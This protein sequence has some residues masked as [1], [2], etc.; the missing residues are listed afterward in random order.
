MNLIPFSTTT[1]SGHLEASLRFGPPGTLVLEFRWDEQWKLVGQG[2]AT[3]AI[4]VRAHELWRST[5]FEA[6]I[7]STNPNT[8]SYLEINVSPRGDWNVY[9]FDGYRN[10]HPPRESTD[11]QLSQFSCGSGRLR[12]VL[13]GPS[14]AFTATRVGLTAVIET[15]DRNIS[16]WALKHPGTQADFHDPR[17]FVAQL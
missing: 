15:T 2:P 3:E 11:W 16:Y 4:G 12:A 7:Q 13:Q 1:L 9:S 10:P 5:C 8:A 17:S 14:S 6:F